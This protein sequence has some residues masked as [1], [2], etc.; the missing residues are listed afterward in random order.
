M[1]CKDCRYFDTED[2]KEGYCQEFV[3]PVNDKCF[4]NIDPAEAKPEKPKPDIVEV[5]RCIHCKHHEDE[6]P[7]MVYCPHFVGS[8][9]LDDFF[10]ANGVKRED[11]NE[12]G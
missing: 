6:Q 12:I 4:C 9:V 1:K 2:G 11:E 10:C 5:V 7:G 8:W 3:Y